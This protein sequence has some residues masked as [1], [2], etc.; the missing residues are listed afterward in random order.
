MLCIYIFCIDSP[1]LLKLGFLQSCRSVLK[2]ILFKNIS[3]FL[4]NCFLLHFI[5]SMGSNFREMK[6]FF[7]SVPKMHV[8][9]TST[10]HRTEDVVSV[11][12]YIIIQKDFLSNIAIN[13]QYK[14]THKVRQKKILI[15][16]LEILVVE[17]Y[18]FLQ[19]RFN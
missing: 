15:L 19:N 13:W 14:I 9:K 11:V 18:S 7:L 4:L 8:S 16:L 2:R 12:V 1:C 5:S 3:M 6:L 10:F 17:A